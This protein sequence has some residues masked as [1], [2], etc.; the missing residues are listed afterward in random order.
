MSV[1]AKIRNKAGLLVAIIGI[2]LFSFV[3][4][5]LLN[6][7]TSFFAS[8]R[9]VIGKI[10]DKKIKITEFG[11]LYENRLRQQQERSGEAVL[12]EPVKEM[13]QK[14]TWDNLLNDVIM[15]K[16][17]ERV[18]VIVGDDELSNMLIGS[19]PHPYVAQAFTNQQTGQI[20]EGY[21]LPDG[22]LNPSKVAEFIQGANQE[23]LDKF[24]KP[25]E[26]SLREARLT[27]KYN[28]LIKKGFYVT[29][30]EAKRDYVEDNKIY[31]AKYVIKR[32]SY[33][34]DS[35]VKVTDA[36][37]KK[38]YNEHKNEFKAKETTRKIDYV[39]FE[40][41]AS[42]EDTAAIF[43]ELKKLTV[44]FKENKTAKDDSLF[45]VRESDSKFFD[46]SYH[47]QGTLPLNI[48]S[49]MF[50]AEKGTILGP[51]I[52]GNQIK[53]AKLIDSKVAP[54]SV[55]ARHI[56]VKI[57][58]TD[59][60]RA[61]NRIDSL[62]SVVSAKNFEELAKKFSEDPG[63]GEKGGDLGWFT[64]GAMVKAFNDACFN[65][66]K[67]D[68]VVVQSDF[69]YHLIEILD[70]GAEARK[71]QVATIDRAITPSSNTLQQYYRKANEFGG[72]YNTPELFEKGI[73]ENKLDKRIADNIKENDKTISGL[74][75]PRE[76]IRWM[77]E[78]DQGNISSVFELGTK[79]IVA[80]LVEVKEKGILPLELVQEQVKQGAIQ[81]KKAEQFIEKF[82]T[83][84]AQEKS[85]ENIAIKM[86]EQVL[87]A[88][89]IKFT[90]NSLPGLGREGKF[91]GSVASLKPKTISQ[92]IKGKAGVY[93][94][95]VD[96]VKEPAA[97]TDYKGIKNKMIG[98]V[99]GRVD[100]EVFEALKSNVDIVDNRSK[101][102]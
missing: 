44:D 33:M 46:E 75:S 71:V 54:D 57:N 16:E 67:G 68:I 91:I 101:F 78:A 26:Q 20:F 5:D 73:A 22:R 66:K 10:G 48:D 95:V 11:A 47:K 80:H 18:G 69:G 3:V 82:N 59:T 83:V 14:Q 41:F 25:M 4:G 19:N 6:S 39:V 40:A 94:L 62:K 7:G 13:I 45:V 30:A 56:L 38:Y 98:S 53:L 92:P 70:K 35:A 99:T 86:E 97:I 102:Y 81:D 42:S 17:F 36:D 89:N 63:S 27:E 61:K 24:I 9:D 96:E 79:Y 31:T 1:L 90:L 23:Q 77:Y 55:K 34:A 85:I 72:K 29:T 87:Q 2:A 21:S 15:K 60:L 64:E 8:E 52:E 43:E 12:E 58:G 76:L 65:G 50:A 74:D 51:Y 100:Y 32:Y 93:V 49:I 37:I 28:N 88:E 84:L